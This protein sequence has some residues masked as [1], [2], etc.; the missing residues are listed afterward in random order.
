MNP[1]NYGKL[2]DWIRGTLWI[3]AVAYAVWHLSQ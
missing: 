2:P 3:I 1:E